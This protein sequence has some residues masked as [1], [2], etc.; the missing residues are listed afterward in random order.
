MNE[1]MCL[2]M[3]NPLS[4]QPGKFC[5]EAYVCQLSGVSVSCAG[6]T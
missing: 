4:W 2:D 3:G 6:Q 5:D 1:W